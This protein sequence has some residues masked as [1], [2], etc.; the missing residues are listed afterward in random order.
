MNFSIFTV[1]LKNR[2]I[3]SKM[4]RSKVTDYAALTLLYVLTTSGVTILKHNV[5]SHSDT[6]SYDK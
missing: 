3:I 2:K 4:K 1:F 5:I 6:T